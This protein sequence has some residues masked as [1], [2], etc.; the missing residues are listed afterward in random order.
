MTTRDP[1]WDALRDRYSVAGLGGR[2]LEGGRPGVIVVDLVNGFT[3]PSF[4]AGSEIDGAVDATRR[5]VEAARSKSVPVVFTTIAF[6][7]EW[8][9]TNVWLRKMPA[10]RG[11]LEGSPWVDV[12]RRLARQPDEPLIV[13]RQASAFGGTDLTSL[14]VS[15]RLD[16]LLVCGATTSGCVRATAVD[17]CM[18][19]WPVFVPRDCVGDRAAAPHEANLFDIDAKYGDVIGMEQ[20]LELVARAQF[21]A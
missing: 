11:L 14:L 12:D 18:L 4:P 17:A 19:G 5:L 6:P 10:M 1:A 21:A 16:S 7:P 20:A 15:L 3:D 9:D 8:I 2:L 13:K